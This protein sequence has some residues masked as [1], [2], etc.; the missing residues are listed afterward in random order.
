MR[1]AYLVV[2]DAANQ[3][4]SGKLNALG[5]GVRVINPTRLPA[6]VPLTILAQAEASSDELGEHPFKVSLE[7]P[8]RKVMTLVEDRLT[9]S[10]RAADEAGLPI[11]FRAQVGFPFVA[12]KAGKYIIR[13]EIGRL[14]ASYPFLVKAPSVAEPSAEGE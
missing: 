7:A 2:A 6:V 5:L 1:M 14:K 9:V 13:L 10:E 11:E 3:G 12:E 8:G 4:P